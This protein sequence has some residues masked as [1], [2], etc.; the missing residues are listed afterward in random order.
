MVNVFSQFTNKFGHGF[1]HFCKIVGDQFP[2]SAAHSGDLV[3]P[4]A[5]CHDQTNKAFIS[6]S[7]L[8]SDKEIVI[9][10]PTVNFSFQVVCSSYCCCRPSLPSQESRRM[11][12]SLDRYLL[13]TIP[14]VV[15]LQKMEM[16]TVKA[17]IQNA[18]SRAETVA[19]DHYNDISILTTHWQSDDTG[20]DKDSSLFLSTI[21]KLQNGTT[22]LT[23][24]TRI[25]E[26]G[27]KI[28]PLL[29]EITLQA[30]EMTG[31]RQLFILHYAGHALATS[32]S[33]S[34][35]ITPRI[36][37]Q[38]FQGPMLNMSL[39]KEALKDMAGASKKGLDV[40]L[41]L[42]CCCA[43][44]AGRGMVNGGRM[45][46]MAATSGGGI[47][48]SRV[49]GDTF[50]QYWCRAFNNFMVLNQPF[51]C[52]DIE[53]NI[54]SNFDLEQ[55]PATFVLR[56]GWGVP[57]TF[58]SSPSSKTL[59]PTALTSRTVITALHIVESPGSDSMNDLIQ[60]LQ[61]CPAEITVLAALKISSTLLLLQVPEYL[62]EMLV[63]P[64]VCLILTDL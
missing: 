42:D 3:G 23:A 34:L 38:E 59:T 63:L 14:A 53:S 16:T 61:N 26:D 22:N 13:E 5:I 31:H 6:S 64:Q 29:N 27:Q 62:Q 4:H 17:R 57:I 2:Y 36:A 35:F 48:N 47:S 43:A 56:E 9:L 40:L 39:I 30:E 24:R 1:C 8:S 18:I 19:L 33:N 46:L 41:L 32:A 50:T 51:S 55:F 45:E 12:N 49:D 11:S 21:S 25:I 7:S 20:G 15:N 54:N 60:Y 44:V 52:S 28:A 10:L 37:L 58:L